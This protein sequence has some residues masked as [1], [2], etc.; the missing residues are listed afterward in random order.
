MKE[1]F[2]LHTGTIYKSQSET[3]HFKAKRSKHMGMSNEK[4]RRELGIKIRTPEESI[5]EFKRLYDEML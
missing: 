4:I 5:R 1:I 3:M 2:E